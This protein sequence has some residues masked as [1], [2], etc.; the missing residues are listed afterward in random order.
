MTTRALIGAVAALRISLGLGALL[1]PRG[2]ASLFGF[3][4][5]QQTPMAVLLGRWLGVR[6]LVL[7]ALALRGHG[8][9]TP[10]DGSSPLGP[11]GERQREFAAINVANDAFDAAAMVVPLVR[12]EGIDR[13]QLIGIPVALG[14][15]A[16]WW[17]ILRS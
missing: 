2:T 14:V 4:S 16:V 15:S 3:P 12:R 9:P 5:S 13:A 8:G 17:R 10:L 1:A 6:E 11:R 7:A